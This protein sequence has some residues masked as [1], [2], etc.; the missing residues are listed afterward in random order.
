[1][2]QTAQGIPGLPDLTHPQELIQFG[3]QLLSSFLTLALLVGALGIV[4]AMIG[5]ALR[6]TQPEQA[7]FIGEWVVRYSQLLRILLH[8]IVVIILLVAGFFLCS[9]LGNRYHHWEQAQVAEIAATVAGERLEQSAPQVRYMVEEQ[10]TYNRQINGRIVRVEDTQE[11]SRLLALA[12]SEIQVTIDQIRN[13]QDQ[14]NHYQIDF[15]ATYQVTNTLAE[16]QEL[17]FEISPPY[18]YSLLQNFRVEQQGRRLE[19]TNPNNYSFP[20]RLEPGEKTEFQVT[21]QAQGAPRWVYN[22][23][24]QL[25]SNFRLTIDTNF[26]QADFASG[27]IPTQMQDQGEGTVFTWLFEDNV[28]VRNPFGVFTATNPITNTGVIPRL[29]LLAPGLFLW[30]ILLLY[31]SLPLSIRNV[32]I[33]GGVF[34]ASLLALTYFSR[35]I[36]ARLAWTGISL[37][38]LVL[39][40][41]LGN[42][43]QTSLAAVVCTI[44]GMVL[45]ILGLLVPYSGLTLSL[46]GLLSMIWLAVL[47]WY[48]VQL[49][50]S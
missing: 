4:I 47:N 45:P 1:M 12:G 32:A 34:F 13:W 16:T 19:P 6:R 23:G 37:V 2:N 5:A 30:W 8:G 22:A 18:G 49:K 20:L 7:I 28:S 43:R 26:L 48:G 3:E 39:V 33:A 50:K 35:V 17:F 24:G 41:G 21:Y 15:T 46:A 9:T 42:D 27:I 31:L 40:W 10:F 44:A 29:L 38:V 25:L 11:V 14:T 36:D